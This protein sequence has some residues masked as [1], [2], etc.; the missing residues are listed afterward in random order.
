VE[1]DQER[2]VERDALQEAADRPEEIGAPDRGPA[3]CELGEAL[4]DA[5]GIGCALP[6]L[7]E[8]PPEVAARADGCAHDLEE[9]EQRRPLSVRD[10]A[11]GE[12]KCASAEPFGERD[13]EPGLADT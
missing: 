2:A 9:R 5:L 3:V 13:C 8:P 4:H 10:G 1:G 7:F 12:C 11:S 6:P